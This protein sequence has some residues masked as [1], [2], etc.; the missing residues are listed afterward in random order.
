MD[1]YE[2][3]IGMS[4]NTLVTPSGPAQSGCERGPQDPEHPAPGPF[5]MSKTLWKGST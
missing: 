4:E 2:G 5:F 3:V 1:I